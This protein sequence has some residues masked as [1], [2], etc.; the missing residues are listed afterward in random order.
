[1]DDN[2]IA[3]YPEPASE[4]DAEH[5]SV[6]ESES[7]LSDAIS[8]ATTDAFE[9]EVNEAYAAQDAAMARE[10][11]ARRQEESPQLEQ[12]P[13]QPEPTP[14]QIAQVLA[15]PRMVPRSRVGASSRAG[16][17]VAA[18]SHPSPQ[19]SLPQ[20]ANSDPSSDQLDPQSTAE[21]PKDKGKGKEVLFDVPAHER[22]LT[23]EEEE[24]LRRLTQAQISHLVEGHRAQITAEA[25]PGIW[26]DFCSMM[27]EDMQINFDRK[28]SEEKEKWAEEKRHLNQKVRNL[29][30]DANVAL[31]KVV[32]KEVELDQERTRLEG[33]QNDRTNVQITELATRDQQI[34]TL[35]QER[36]SL[37]DE[38]EGL[39]RQRDE[40]RVEGRAILDAER[41]KRREAEDEA[42]RIRAETG[43]YAVNLE[44]QLAAQ[45]QETARVRTRLFSERRSNEEAMRARVRQQDRRAEELTRSYRDQLQQLGANQLQGQDH[46]PPPQIAAGPTPRPTP[47]STDARADQTFAD[48]RSRSEDLRQELAKQKATIES[49]Q[50]SLADCRAKA[51][52]PP[53]D[54]CEAR[55][56]ALQARLEAKHERELYER[57]TWLKQRSREDIDALRAQKDAELAKA[58]ANAAAMAE[59]EL[60]DRGKVVDGLHKELNASR[61]ETE[62]QVKVSQRAEAKARAHY[63]ESHK[64]WRE[65]L[66]LLAEREEFGAECHAEH[67]RWSEQ[68]EVLR[69]DLRHAER[70]ASELEME[71]EDAEAATGSLRT[72]IQ[73]L[74][75]QI[76][77]LTAKARAAKAN[78]KSLDKAAGAEVYELRRR[79]V[80]SDDATKKE[81]DEVRR[82][83]K[84]VNGRLKAWK[85]EEKARR[86]AASKAKQGGR[87]M[88]A[89]LGVSEKAIEGFLRPHVPWWKLVFY[90]LLMW[91]FFAL[92][93]VRFFAASAATSRQMHVRED[94]WLDL[95]GVMYGVNGGGG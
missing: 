35:T 73:P 62:R 16:P 33:Q 60:L 57:E 84:F 41:R 32:E 89:P 37:R 47:R 78:Y 63:E 90:Q 9:L 11:E 58:A 23:R 36:G 46:P 50:K 56:Q 68:T 88:D 6:E 79:L 18:S 31:S 61:A 40:L 74:E 72:K 81:A 85:A 59:E 82:L 76:K 42:T 8:I 45:T 52:Q 39:R 28:L 3:H 67:Q 51:K 12:T 20:P 87:E 49:L 86:M 21:P 92:V 91:L 30:R 38:A 29:E 15:R 24:G 93:A 77:G 7:E 4:D 75:E 1:M 25:R 43:S 83:K 70:R 66:R 69:N 22:P 65:N 71:K 26:A 2:N 54:T 10:A 27:E 34:Q 5:E 14:E 53:V 48:L 64:F 94:P 95:S 19:Q 55:L 13:E 17:S 44:Q 80:L